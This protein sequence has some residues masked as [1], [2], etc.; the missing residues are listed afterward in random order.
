MH[1]AILNL[2]DTLNRQD[3]EGKST[4]S[5]KNVGS[6]LIDRI[7][8][9]TVDHDI[10]LI[11]LVGDE[12]V[13]QR[14]DQET[15]AIILVHAHRSDDMD[16]IL[17]RSVDTELVAQ[18]NTRNL[19]VIRENPVNTILQETDQV[20]VSNG[21][22]HN[23]GGAQLS[24][25]LSNRTLEPLTG[26]LHPV[27]QTASEGI[28]GQSIK[29]GLSDHDVVNKLIVL[30]E[31]SKT[32]LLSLEALLQEHIDLSILEVSES[33]THDIDVISNDINVLKSQSISSILDG[34]SSIQTRARLRH[35]LLDV[36]NTTLNAQRTLIEAVSSLTTKDNMSDSTSSAHQGDGTLLE[37]NATDKLIT[38]GLGD[39]TSGIVDDL[40][41]DLTIDKVVSGNIDSHVHSNLMIGTSRILNSSSNNR[42]ARSELN[43]VVTSN[44]ARNI[45]RINQVEVLEEIDSNGLFLDV[46]TSSLI[47][48]LL[49]DLIVI[50]G[51]GQRIL[52]TLGVLSITT[53][54]TNI[55]NGGLGNLSHEDILEDA[56]NPLLLKEERVISNNGSITS[57]DRLSS[58][59]IESVI[60]KLLN[61]VDIRTI[62]RI[63]RSNRVGH[64]DGVRHR[65][66]SSANESLLSGRSSNNA[67]K[68]IDQVNT[69]SLI[70]FKHA[71]DFGL[72]A[73][74][75][76][77]VL[78]LTDDLGI[79]HTIV[80]NHGTNYL[81]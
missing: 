16:A 65:F 39:I 40:I 66:R 38:N 6:Q 11:M 8:I 36:L 28:K 30:N 23:V 22:D 60:K 35:D 47:K 79:I 9:V 5:S 59:A 43:N 13:G 61:T 14:N 1:I 67:G 2:H 20:G 56:V 33:S 50:Q 80:V 69:L 42:E 12:L 44:N 57:H 45:G 51:L 64:Q 71:L 74:I 34:N 81:L 26:I 63:L 49:G 17:S 46:E 37:V 25:E 52:V 53:L 10:V 73:D 75:T 70:R 27:G 31:V 55:D 21:N 78:D 54:K 4:L 19:S 76:I 3:L 7:T 77:R 29:L 18:L 48:K 68:I 15:N 24:L 41:L 32:I 62:E 72:K 58:N